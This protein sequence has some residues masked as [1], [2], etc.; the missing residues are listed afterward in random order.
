M[1]RNSLYENLIRSL[2]AVDSTE[3]AQFLGD[4][5][6]FIRIEHGDWRHRAGVPIPLAAPVGAAEASSGV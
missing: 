2:Y 6:S 4:L 5:C 3:A 1:K